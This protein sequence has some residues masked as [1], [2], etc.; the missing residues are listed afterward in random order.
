M[1]QSKKLMIS[2]NHNGNNK[3]CNQKCITLIKS[4][5]SLKISY[6]YKKVLLKYL[7]Y[8]NKKNHTLYTVVI[9]N[10]NQ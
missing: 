8:T 6:W 9:P 2:K 10:K 5:L 3:L 7:N 1:L 4:T